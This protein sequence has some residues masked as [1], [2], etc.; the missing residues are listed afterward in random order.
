ML[1]IFHGGKKCDEK[2][3][4]LGKDL[5]A[6]RNQILLGEVLDAEVHFSSAKMIKPLIQLS[7]ALVVLTHF[8]FHT[9]MRTLFENVVFC[10]SNSEKCFCM[11]RRFDVAVVDIPGK[12]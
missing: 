11:G 1:L 5:T 4:L 3:D 9:V 2:G 12:G 6:F 7:W 8:L 10:I